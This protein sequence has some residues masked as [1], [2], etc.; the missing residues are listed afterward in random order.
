[1]A[2]IAPSNDTRIQTES[3]KLVSVN[4]A[5]QTLSIGK[6]KLYDLIKQG[7]IRP[8]KIGRRTL[9]RLDDLDAF[10]AGLPGLGGRQ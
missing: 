5:L 7:V 10:I 6:T 8:A 9:I 4:Y 3:L 1:M 2:Y